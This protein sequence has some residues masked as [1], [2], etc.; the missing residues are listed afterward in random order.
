MFVLREEI[1]MNCICTYMSF[2][3]NIFFM[4]TQDDKS[5]VTVMPRSAVEL[6]TGNCLPLII[7]L[8]QTVLLLFLPEEMQRTQHL[9]VDTVNCQDFS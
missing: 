8:G 3:N 5:F 2:S 6:T 9:P 1:T 4:C 7:R